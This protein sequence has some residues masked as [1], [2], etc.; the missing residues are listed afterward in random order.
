M[1]LNGQFDKTILPSYNSSTIEYVCCKGIPTAR[2]PGIQWGKTGV[3]PVLSRNCNPQAVRLL[4]S[5]IARLCCT[6]KTFE[7]KG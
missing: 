1:R 6:P 2:K 4:E 7:A 5:Q 3:S